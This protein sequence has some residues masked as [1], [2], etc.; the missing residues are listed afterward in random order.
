VKE[1]SHEEREW[2]A[3]EAGAQRYKREERGN[4]NT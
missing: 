1:I 2:L 4:P 3:Y